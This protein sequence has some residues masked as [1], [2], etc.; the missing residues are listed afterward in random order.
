MEYGNIVL[1]NIP[2]GSFKLLLLKSKGILGIVQ[3]CVQTPSGTQLHDDDRIL[4][5][6][7]PGK[8]SKTKKKFRLRSLTVEG[9]TRPRGFS[10]E[11]EVNGGFKG[12][13]RV[14]RGSESN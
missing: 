11:P 1:T 6:L 14:L 3:D 10:K 12:K 8:Q 7:L 4:A 5:D 2:E 13:Q 9:L